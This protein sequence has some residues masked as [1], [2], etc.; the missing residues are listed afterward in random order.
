MAPAQQLEWVALLRS[1]GVF[2]MRKRGYAR[3]KALRECLISDNFISMSCSTDEGSA[4]RNNS[5]QLAGDEQ[6]IQNRE[7]PPT[8]PI[9]DAATANN[10]AQIE[11]RVQYQTTAQNSSEA[12]S[13]KTVM[14]SPHQVTNYK[15]KKMPTEADETRRGTNSQNSS[16]SSP[17]PGSSGIQGLMKAYIGR[18][19]FTG[20][21]DEDLNSALETLNTM[22]NLC[23][24]SLSE[25]SEGMPVMLR[26]EALT[27]YN[28]NYKPGDTFE[29]IADRFRSWYT[30]E[31]QRHRLLSEWQYIRFTE[32]MNENPDK[33]EMEVFRKLADRLTN[34]QR[35]LD[36]SY[37]AD[38]LLRD[39][40]IIA[41]DLPLIKRSLRERVPRTA[42]E[43]IP[44]VAT[45]LSKEKG[46]AGAYFNFEE[47]GIDDALYSLGNKFG[48][49]AKKSLKGRGKRGRQ[50]SRKLSSKWLAG[51]KGCWV[52]GQGHL[53][54]FKHT[55]EEVSKA[56]DRLR[57][58]HP[59]AMLTVEDVAL[60]TESLFQDNKDS[61]TEVMAVYSDDDDDDDYLYIA[62]DAFGL[63][64]ED[65][66][67]LANNSFVHGRSFTKDI[68][69]DYAYMNEELKKG[70]KDTFDGLRLDTCANRSSVMSL[71]RYKA[72]CRQFQVPC[73]I[74]HSDIRSLRGLGGRQTPIGSVTI[75]VPFNDLNLVMDVKFRIVHDHIPTLLS[76]KDM[77]DN[78]LDFSI[79]RRTMF[80][81]HK[82]H[83]LSLE[84]YF[85][86]HR[87]DHGDMTYSLYTESELH[88]LHRVF[89]H[90]SV[91]A[92][93]NLLSR[94]HPDKL[95][96]EAKDQLR[97]LTEACV[98]CSVNASRPRRFK[99][100][101]GADDLRFNHIVAVDIMYIHNR[102]VLHL[103]D[104]ATHYS[105]AA[106]LKSSKSTEVWK[107]ILRCWARVYLGP[108][109]FL[110]I[111][112]G[113]NF[114]SKEFLD[115][116]DADGISVMSAPIESANT[117]SHVERYH[118][119]IRTAFNKIRQSVPKTE[120][121]DDCLH[122]A[123][124]SVNDTIGP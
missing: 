78:D 12:N 82:E 21:Y 56:L 112:Q 62:E 70:E 117:M 52:C 50:A 83:Q 40:L 108:P 111:D 109:D 49:E 118:S 16:G 72:Y 84:N 57:E 96:K 87:W 9:A 122:M 30:S 90:P 31:E 100:T 54:R 15:R 22:C 10:D 60:I 114:I 8:E 47:H 37:H 68:E 102:P 105:A 124:K 6:Y 119:C 110:R 20:A 23:H 46:S 2:V 95:P 55:R 59:S 116:A 113:S 26:D 28:R 106:F 101:V 5:P 41:V 67:N 58:K 32:V 18:K 25:K 79:K 61:D 13:D 94:A 43:A 36:K 80:H 7:H 73:R 91:S 3:E 24:L 27:F 66:V 97:K 89:G 39:Q 69:R 81:K 63:H 51:I 65:E 11:R 38:H 103:V 53:A 88:R 74:N 42:Q 4:L 98:T 17:V 107:T 14:N 120:S 86:I 123:V 45:F 77:L 19:A 75:P 29:D 121:D 71:S 99:L 33:S 104:E 1:R 35:Q 85:L 64:R 92:L 93:I 44:R 34:L 48:G 115:S 76:M